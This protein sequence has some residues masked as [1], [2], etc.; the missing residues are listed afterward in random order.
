[1]VDSEHLKVRIWLNI[2]TCTCTFLLTEISKIKSLFK[3]IYMFII[4]HQQKVMNF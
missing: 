3:C 2:G 1:M 4:I